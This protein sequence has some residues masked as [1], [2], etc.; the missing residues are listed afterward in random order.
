MQVHGLIA[1]V[2]LSKKNKLYFVCSKRYQKV[3]KP[4][5]NLKRKK[6]ACVTVYENFIIKIHI[7]KYKI[8]IQWCVFWVVKP[9]MY[10][11][12]KSGAYVS[13]VNRWQITCWN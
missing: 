7:R 4:H 3:R 8:H 12:I 5:A 2:Q 10:T 13:R 6:T 1:I 9:N 11:L